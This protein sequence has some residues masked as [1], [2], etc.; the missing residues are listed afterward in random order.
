MGK[1]TQQALI[2]ALPALKPTLIINKTTGEITPP[3]VF[4]NDLEQLV[5]TVKT[6]SE[7]YYL[8]HRTLVHKE[9]LTYTGAPQ[10]AEFARQKGWVLTEGLPRGVKAKSRVE[11]LAR[12]H[13]VQ[14]V[15]SF[16]LNPNSSKQEPGFG[17]SVNLGAVDAQMAGLT[18]EGNQLILAFKCWENEYLLFFTLPAYVLTRNILKISLPVIRLNKNNEW[19]YGYTIQE[20]PLTRVKGTQKAGLDLGRVEPYTMVV[21]NQDGNRIAAYTTSGRLK[22]LNHKRERLLVEKKHILTKLDHYKNLNHTPVKQEVLQKEASYK[23][24]KITRLGVTIAH[25]VGSEVTKKLVKHKVSTLNL[26]NLKWVQGAKYGSKWNHSK[27]Q[28][29][30]THSLK[31]TG[32]NTKFVNP[33]NTSQECYKC[34]TKLVHNTK[35][36]TVWCVECKTKLD[37]DYNAAMN[38]VRDKNN[39]S[40]PVPSG[41]TGVTLVPITEQVTRSSFLTS[42]LSVRKTT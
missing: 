23:R 35:S 3:A 2:S 6:R 34:N 38:I 5:H 18:R 1:R 15:T 4:N 37:R 7:Q 10:A 28:E 39:N 42:V 22:Q 31:Q 41:N 14:T 17:L 40:S 33:K 19:V 29:H 36:R 32:I 9:L 16:V 13:L 27:Q 24:D 11:R 20:Q 21:T 26:E 12:Y 30:I 8:N 25:H